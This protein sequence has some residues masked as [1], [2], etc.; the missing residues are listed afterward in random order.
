VCRIDCDT[1]RNFTLFSDQRS[2]VVVMIL[3]KVLNNELSF[4]FLPLN[5]KTRDG[6]IG[7]LNLFA[8]T[9]SFFNNGRVGDAF[10]RFNS[11]TCSDNKRGS[12]VVDSVG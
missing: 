5:D 12:A 3:I 1:F 6:L 8:V 2:V 4:K 11:I 10:V 9:Q 7:V